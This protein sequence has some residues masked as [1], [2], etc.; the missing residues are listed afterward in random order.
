MRKTDSP[1]PV[2]GHD[3]SRLIKI[4]FGKNE[5]VQQRRSHR[6]YISAQTGTRAPNLGQMR[7]IAIAK[8]AK[9]NQDANSQGS[10]FRG[11]RS[12]TIAKILPPS[13]DG[14]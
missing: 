7:W 13:Q 6:L 10:L 1:L 2:H 9:A 4:R 3:Q 11:S 5:T 14:H 12:L 8:R